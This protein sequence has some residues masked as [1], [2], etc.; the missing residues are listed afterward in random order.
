M[1]LFYSSVLV[2]F[3]ILGNQV[4]K[5]LPAISH[6]LF[7]IL[8]LFSADSA[9]QP[10]QKV[11][12]ASETQRSCAS[13]CV[14]VFLTLCKENVF[15]VYWRIRSSSSLFQISARQLSLPS[16]SRCLAAFRDIATDI[17]NVD[18][19]LEESLDAYIYEEKLDINKKIKHF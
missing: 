10:A 7:I 19:V 12:D 2:Q 13:L 8:K 11:P 16:S 14:Y 3:N 18:L 5:Y 4:R 9:V 17:S 6:C 15:D 1:F